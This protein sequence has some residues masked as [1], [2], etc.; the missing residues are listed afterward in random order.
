[1]GKIFFLFSHFHFKFAQNEPS[2]I[3]MQFYEAFD[4]RRVT[5]KE[6]ERLLGEGW[7]RVGTGFFRQRYYYDKKF[8]NSKA[9]C[10]PLRYNLTKPFVLSKSQQK[11]LRQNEDLK[12]IIR[13]LQLDDEQYELFE[14]W[15]AS[16]FD[17]GSPLRTWVAGE[18]VPFRSHQ[19]CVYKHDRLIA[20]SYFDIVRKAQYST[21]AGYDPDEMKRSLGTFTLLK[22]IEL[23]LQKNRHYHH[24][25]YAYFDYTAFDYKKRFPNPE[26]FS[27]LAFEWRPLVFPA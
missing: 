12:T 14:R 18:K 20:I 25:G 27:W 21:V 4:S 3:D 13:P 24:P 16:R 5:L 10:M 22:E 11:V 7:D 8:P 26:Y 19:V 15:E 23:A 1:M 2:M 17:V 9:E 6:W